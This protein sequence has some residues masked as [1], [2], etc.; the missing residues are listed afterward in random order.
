MICNLRAAIAAMALVS[1]APASAALFTYN[2]TA[3]GQGVETYGGNHNYSCIAGNCTSTNVAE[4][5]NFTL[6]GS[7]TVDTSKLSFDNSSGANVFH[8]DN[9]PNQDPAAQFLSGTMTK[10][11]GALPM[12]PGTGGARS[13][14]SGY[15]QSV[16]GQGF[17]QAMAQAPGSTFNYQ[18]EY[19]QNGN[20]ARLYYREDTIGFYAYDN[21][22]DV[23]S[24]EGYDLATAFSEA[25]A[26]GFAHMSFYMFEVLYDANG[27]QTSYSEAQTYA[28]A[29][30]TSINAAPGGPTEVPEPAMLGLFGLGIAGLAMGR[31]RKAA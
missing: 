25:I 16:Y 23:T 14:L 5:E 26:G 4:S 10:T 12:S 7:F 11:G 1:T 15:D 3:G 9:Y 21:G 13:Y 17:F 18:Y 20:L 24:F 2:F 30:I 22:I 28:Q 31:R 19:H 27:S 8:Y 29:R 6:S